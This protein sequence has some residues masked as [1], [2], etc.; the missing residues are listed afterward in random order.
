MVV[1]SFDNLQPSVVW[2]KYF[3]VYYCELNK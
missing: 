1:E 3:W 2:I